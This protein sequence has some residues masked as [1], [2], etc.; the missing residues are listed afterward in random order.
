[1]RM[2]LCSLLVPLLFACGSGPAPVAAATPDLALAPVADLASATSRDL[3]PPPG[4]A[5]ASTTWTNFAKQFCASYCVGCHGPKT[6]D[7]K[8][9][10]SLLA[11]VT[12]DAQLVGCGVGTIAANAN[13]NGIAPRQFPVGGGAK[14]SDA[15][16]T[17]FIEWLNAGSPM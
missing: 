6:A 4:D 7:Q 13:C 5:A 15:E 11:D 10:Y 2:L 9:D 12:R 1:M 17:R 14:P 3:A 8:R 16:R